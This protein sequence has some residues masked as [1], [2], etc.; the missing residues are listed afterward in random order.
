MK[1]AA[2][3][4]VA[5]AL[6]AVGFVGCDKVSEAV[7]NATQKGKKIT[8]LASN[9]AQSNSNANATAND[10]AIKADNSGYGVKAVAEDSVCKTSTNIDDYSGRSYVSGNI[11]SIIRNLNHLKVGDEKYWESK[12][13]HYY[14][15]E[16]KKKRQ[17]DCMPCCAYAFNRLSSD[18]FDTARNRAV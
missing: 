3:K 16:I 18:R 14:G 2:L 11:S 4:V 10:N 8:Q 9:V 5:I 12:L 7:D 15:G 13:I 1:K 17:R 6:V